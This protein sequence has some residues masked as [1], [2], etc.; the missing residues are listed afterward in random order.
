MNHSGDV[1]GRVTRS[2]AQ[3]QALESLETVASLANCNKKRP[4]A[5]KT[6]SRPNAKAVCAP[7]GIPV[8]QNSSN[9][10]SPLRTDRLLVEPSPSNTASP[11]RI[12]RE[13]IEPLSEKLCKNIDTL[14]VQTQ[15]ARSRS[16]SQDPDEQTRVEKKNEGPTIT[17]QQTW[18]RSSRSKRSVSPTAVVKHEPTLDVETQARSTSRKRGR[19]QQSSTIEDADLRQVA[20]TADGAVAQ[21][22]D[23]DSDDSLCL[24]TERLDAVPAENPLKDSNQSAH[25]SSHK[26]TFNQDNELLLSNT[27]KTR[28]Q[29]EL[30]ELLAQKLSQQ[31]I[32]VEPF[33][34]ELSQHESPK[35]KAKKGAKVTTKTPA[36]HRSRQKQSQI[37]NETSTTVFDGLSTLSNGPHTRHRILKTPATGDPCDFVDS[38]LNFLTTGKKSSTALF[39]STSAKSSKSNYEIVFDSDLTDITL[40]H[41]NSPANSP[42]MSFAPAVDATPLNRPTPI[43]YQNDAAPSNEF[44]PHKKLLSTAMIQNGLEEGDAEDEEDEELD[45]LR[46]KRRRTVKINSEEDAAAD[47]VAAAIPQ[48][49]DLDE[50]QGGYTPHDSAQNTA[51]VSNHEK[52]DNQLQERDIVMET[53]GASFRHLSTQ[54]IC[55]PHAFA[56]P[57]GVAVPLNQDPDD[58]LDVELID[59]EEDE[60]QI[61]AKRPK[62]HAF[63]KRNTSLEKLK[64]SKGKKLEE[65]SRKISSSS[66]T[67]NRDSDDLSLSTLRERKGDETQLLT[68]LTLATAAAG[69]A[70]EQSVVNLSNSYLNQAVASS[71]TNADVCE[72]LEIGRC[73][74]KHSAIDDTLNLNLQSTNLTLPPKPGIVA[75]FAIN[76]IGQL[77]NRDES[78]LAGPPRVDEAHSQTAE[79]IKVTEGAYMQTTGENEVMYIE[80]PKDGGF[81]MDAVDVLPGADA[82]RDNIFDEIMQRNLIAAND[83]LSLALETNKHQDIVLDKNEHLDDL[84]ATNQRHALQQGTTQHHSLAHEAN[85]PHTLTPDVAI[86]KPIESMSQSELAEAVDKLRDIAELSMDMTKSV[87]IQEA[88]HVTLPL[89]EKPVCAC[90]AIERNQLSVSCPLRLAPGEFY[91]YNPQLPKTLTDMINKFTDTSPGGL[92]AYLKKMRFQPPFFEEFNIPHDTSSPQLANTIS[93]RF[94]EKICKHWCEARAQYEDCI[95]ND[96]YHVTRDTSMMDEI[97]EWYNASKGLRQSGNPNIAPLMTAQRFGAQVVLV[98]PYYHH[99]DFKEIQR[100]RDLNHFRDYLRSFFSAL[101]SVHEAGYMHRDVKPNNFLYYLTT[102]T[103][104]LVDFGLAQAANGTNVSEDQRKVSS[105]LHR[106]QKEVIAALNEV[107]AGSSQNMQSL[108]KSG[109]QGRQSHLSKKTPQSKNLQRDIKATSLKPPTKNVSSRFVASLLPPTKHKA[110]ASPAP[111]LK[112]KYDELKGNNENKPPANKLLDISQKRNQAIER[113]PVQQ[114]PGYYVNDKRPKSKHQRAGTR[115]FR[116]P[117][118]MFG[119]KNQTTAID[120]WS[121]GVVFLSMLSGRYPF[122]LSLG[123]VEGLIEIA[124]IFGKKAMDGLAKSLDRSFRTNVKIEKEGIPLEKLIVAFRPKDDPIVNDPRFTVA[125]DLLKKCLTLNPNERITAAE[126]LMHPFLLDE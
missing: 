55:A 30:F 51:S 17:V 116:A 21:I 7:N 110:I 15:R 12:D 90:E 53:A 25:R 99:S 69:F 29:K 114:N 49:M 73:E 121:V 40:S 27:P 126:A 22:K 122:F 65:E 4:T 35:S 81:S 38:E 123:D 43:D 37:N 78:I 103:G 50:H 71:L 72:V 34:H 125:L 97:S 101:H 19:Y 14:I 36:T 124:R 28:K 83:L 111:P 105:N 54:L 82:Q 8:V 23:E 32:E 1:N 118:V 57:I 24:S 16:V 10:Q 56:T 74:A 89:T 41:V 115:G 104:V 92:Y 79:L 117:E 61:L 119:V 113:Q 45:A 2:R 60:T 106:P 86:T 62:R 98:L 108:S 109:E 11:T 58:I 20:P 93:G 26:Q 91:Y 63:N 75:D 66:N 107:E 47:E 77:R 9:P 70:E 94:L 13:L 48:C 76:G 44:S 5:K 95:A 84:Q 46:A 6:L 112:R 102:R 67:Q 52:L 31:S 88:S 3:G 33:Q 96:G 85:D 100:A 59:E 80:L 39:K 64:L 42:Y 87:S 18:S 120:I 68:S